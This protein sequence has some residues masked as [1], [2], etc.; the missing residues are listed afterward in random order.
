MQPDFASS[1]IDCGKQMKWLISRI[2]N[3]H[4]PFCMN[5]YKCSLKHI[6][7]IRMCIIAPL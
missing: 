6:L 7:N 4:H 1:N 2:V 3:Q 5:E